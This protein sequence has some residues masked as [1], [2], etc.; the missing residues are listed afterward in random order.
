MDTTSSPTSTEDRGIDSS[1]SIDPEDTWWV[2][3]AAGA[4]VGLGV[5]LFG[6][7]LFSKFGKK[8]GAG[9][10]VESSYKRH[11][12]FSDETKAEPY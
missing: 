7:L 1:D 9:S 10:A 12:G 3:A 8:A 5:V 11:N 2:A 4:G 6:A